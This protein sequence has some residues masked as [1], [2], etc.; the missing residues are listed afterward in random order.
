MKFYSAVVTAVFVSACAGG[1]QEGRSSVLSSPP[2]VSPRLVQAARVQ[3]PEDVT[4]LRYDL[5][6]D[7]DPNQAT[8]SGHTRIAINVNAAT[9]NIV[10]H[11]RAMTIT[12]ATLDGRPL[13]TQYR[14]AFGAKEEKEEL[15]LAPD[16]P[17]PVGEHTIDLDYT[18]P[19]DGHLRG[20]YKV[21]QGGKAYAFTQL[22]AV[23]ARRMFP[24]FD[25][26]RFK[27]PFTLHVR[28][29]EGM[30]V[31]SNAA[32]EKKVGTTWDF[33][34]TL[35]LPTYLV[36]LA[37][38]DLEITEG[39]KDPVPIRIV[40]LPGKGNL[41][42]LALEAASAYLKILSSYFDRTYPYGKLDVVAVP[43]FGP[44]A[45]ENAGLVTFRE[46]LLL[47]DPKQAPVWARRRM[48][49]VMAHELA[50][51]WFGDL[52][53][54]KWWDDIWLNEGFATW[55]TAKA[56]D[57]RNPAMQNRME[58]VGGKLGVMNAD[59][60]ASAH[61]VRSPVTTSDS[62]LDAGGWTAY[63]KG[64][65]LLTMLESHVGENAFRDGIRA[66]LK[67]HEFGVVTSDDLIGSVSKAT[68]KD[69][70][71][72]AKSFLDQPGV[73][74][75]RMS[76]ACEPA[77]AKARLTQTALHALGSQRQAADTKWAI[78]V[79][80][81]AEGVSEPIC[82]RL[83]QAS[84][85]VSL[86]KC[87]AWVEPNAGEAGYYRW[88]VPTEMLRALAK[89]APK[90]LDERERAAL[91]SNTWALVES[92]ELTPSDAFEVL[93]LVEVGRDSSRLVV[94]QAIAMLTSARDAVI[95]D[96]ARPRFRSLVKRVLGPVLLRLGEEPRPNETEEDR[97]IRIAV[98]GALFDLAED[99]Q[100]KATAEKRVRTW[101]TT[102][103]AIDPDLA[104]LSL[105]IS[106]RAQGSATKA[107][108]FERLMTANPSDRVILT[109]AL[110][111]SP[112]PDVIQSGI[113]GV[114]SG[115]IRAGDFRYLSNAAARQPDSRAIFIDVVMKH[116]DEL[117]KRLG[118]GGLG[119]LVGWT[120]DRKTQSEVGQFFR[121]RSSHLEGA[122]RAFDEGMDRSN[123]CIELRERHEA[124]IAKSL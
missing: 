20:L 120:C 99:A 57:L 122:Q 28:A 90:S 111:S 58:L 5:S 104:A 84:A 70:T 74:L 93:G 83:D 52:V 21:E 42:G 89:A 102:P 23:D 47:V 76:L 105:R 31:V 14:F 17:V 18:A 118:G 22:E 37:V 116:F 86:P 71:L 51:Q 113:S 82:A 95:N 97:L 88:S 114:I 106:A 25:E 59:A 38:G 73:P 49:A 30:T 27:T 54:M 64:Q 103:A 8:F 72:I 67:S 29:P 68:G 1:H 16:E 75:V 92:G 79:C 45:M 117:R 7:V 65:A 36:A 35:P 10:L 56:V 9:P 110:G 50:H 81:R 43:D 107:I 98:T 94:E 108:I 91:L 66:Y 24:G 53:T 87:P 48:E 69:L 26:P 2:P 112:D 62:I 41:G 34:P 3:L 61:R 33:K 60:L 121:D 123:L 6:L 124:S 101:L 39:P 78:P 4:P 63:L 40:T 13:S 44:G 19:Y 46:E 15:V 96:A 77:G 100:V 115:T 55:M 119:E 85:E 11:A 80:L 109:T 32:L 12:K